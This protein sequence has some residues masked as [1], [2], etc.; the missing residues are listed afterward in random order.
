ME[1]KIIHFHGPK[2]FQ[3]NYIDSHWPELKPLTGGAYLA[4]VKRWTELLEEAR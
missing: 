4:Q 1:A 3:R 2:P